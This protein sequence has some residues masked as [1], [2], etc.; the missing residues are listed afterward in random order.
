MPEW[1]IASA[2]VALFLGIGVSFK[3]AN[4]IF[5]PWDTSETD[6]ILAMWQRIR[7]KKG[8]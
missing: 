4:R 3:L 1:I 6:K 8:N 5:P 7:E 2:I